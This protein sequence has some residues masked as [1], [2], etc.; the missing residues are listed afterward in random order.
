MI[1]RYVGERTL[2]DAEAIAVELR[3]AISTVRAKCTVAAI[4]GPTKRKL[5]DRAEAEVALSS[6][7]VRAEHARPTR[8][9]G[10][11]L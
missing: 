4:D 6:V 3:R 9:R 7:P 10:A 1:V 8:R 2:M 5:Y 11:A